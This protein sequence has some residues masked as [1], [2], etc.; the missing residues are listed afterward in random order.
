MACD[1][2]SKN[3]KEQTLGKAGLSEI[4]ESSGATIVQVYECQ[5]H[6]IIKGLERS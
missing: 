6:L 2:K 5:T 4:L 1:L 3:R